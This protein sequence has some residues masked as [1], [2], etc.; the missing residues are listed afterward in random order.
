MD[1]IR[2]LETLEA[3]LIKQKQQINRDSTRV[4]LI[5]EEKPIKKVNAT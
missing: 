3:S 2:E 4:I 1:A 5:D